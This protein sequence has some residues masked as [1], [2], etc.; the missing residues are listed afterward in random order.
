M[1]ISAVR[2]RTQ[3]KIKN[4][5][6]FSEEY[7]PTVRYGMIEGGVHPTHYDNSRKIIRIRIETDFEKKKIKK[8]LPVVREDFFPLVY[9]YPWEQ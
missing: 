3:F 2:K 7:L 4:I 1:R 5:F 9:V 8:L 6:I